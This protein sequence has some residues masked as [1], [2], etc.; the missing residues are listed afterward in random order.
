MARLALDIV[1]D[2]R[3]TAV[4]QLLQ[5]REFEIGIDL[6]VGLDQI[7][8]RLEPGKRTAQILQVL[9]RAG[10]GPCGFG[11]DSHFVDPSSWQDCPELFS[12]NTVQPL[13]RRC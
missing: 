1:E 6:L 11:S 3:T 2:D 9:L 5:A 13:R 4:H 12:E 8:A 10:F 7:T